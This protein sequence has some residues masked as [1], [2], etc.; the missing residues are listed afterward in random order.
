MVQNEEKKEAGGSR[1][2]RKQRTRCEAVMTG[3]MATLIF[4]F[5]FHSICE[6]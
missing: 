5:I 3:F 1:D 4:A 6:L 2:V